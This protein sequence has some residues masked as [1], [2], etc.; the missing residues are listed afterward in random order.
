MSFASLFLVFCAL[1]MVSVSYVY[2]LTS[3]FYV[4]C[5]CWL[6]AVGTEGKAKVKIGINGKP[7]HFTL[8]L[9][10]LRYIIANAISWAAF[11]NSSNLISFR[12]RSN[13][14]IGG[15][16]CPWARWYRVGGHQRSFHQPWVHGNLP[17]PLTM[18]RTMYMTS[19]HN[20]FSNVFSFASR[21]LL[22]VKWTIEITLFDIC[23]LHV[24][25]LVTDLHV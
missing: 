25:L 10:S 9:M 19:L 21:L 11:L 3:F 2:C 24:G 4:S 22:R 18:L 12:V 7:T 5:Y 16:R 13:W 1:H 15:S 14:P 23:G 17:S 6:E 8:I 20:L